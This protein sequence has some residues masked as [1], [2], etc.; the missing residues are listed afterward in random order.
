MNADIRQFVEDVIRTIPYMDPQ[1]DQVSALSDL[2]NNNKDGDSTTAD[3]K[4]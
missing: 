4:V 3:Q 1:E 2:F